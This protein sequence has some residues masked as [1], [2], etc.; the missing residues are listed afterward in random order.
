[1][2]PATSAAQDPHTSLLNAARTVIFMASGAGKAAILKRIWE[3]EEE[4]R[5]PPPWS[6]FARGDFADFRK[7]QHSNS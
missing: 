1:M 6:S 4:N 3:D 7:R 2:P 5:S